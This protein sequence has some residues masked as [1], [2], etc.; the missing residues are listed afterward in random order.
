MKYL[1]TGG[2]GFIGRAIIREIRKREPEAEV[3]AFQRSPH[4]DLET[5]G[6]E[7]RCGSLTD[8][9]AVSEACAGCDAVF[10]VAAKAGIWGSW[11]SYYEPNVIGTR[12]VLYGCKGNGPRLLVYTSS[13]SV[14]F[15]GVPIRGGSEELP[16]P[17]KWSFHYAHTKALA[18]QAVLDAHR[19]GEGPEGLRTIALRPHLVWGAGDPHI[20]PRIL[21]QAR[22][23]KLKQVGAGQ[24]RVDMT[25]VRNVA[26]A[27]WLALENLRSGRVGG[28]A[29][30]VSDDAPVVLW[31]WVK[32]LLEKAG[33]PPV[34]SR[35]PEKM[36][37]R[38]GGAL[39]WAYRTFKIK[40]EPPLTRFVAQ[41]MAEDHWFD[42]SAA[43]RDLGYEPVVSPEEGMEELLDWLKRTVG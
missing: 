39:E 42:I 41:Q 26:Y 31:E 17:E 6:V 22:A 20:V 30:F 18:E 28:R 12:N 11:E 40:G 19:P 29:Y 27:H 34:R 14:V 7:V 25:H 33:A 3:I 21:E 2:G 38:L 36:A 23:G 35:V 4:P 24:N 8:P 9:G 13:P 5:E 16:Y 15:G 1:V 32:A 10:H 37:L 43:R